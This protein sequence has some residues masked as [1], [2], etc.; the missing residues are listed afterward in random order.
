M[1]EAILL[2][3][4]IVKASRR[5]KLKRLNSEDFSG[6][7][8]ADFSVW[9]KAELKATDAFLMATWGA[10][11]VKIIIMIALSGQRFEMN[12]WLAINGLIILLWLI[13]LGI[14][15]SLGSKAKKLKLAAGIKWPK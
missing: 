9:H 12:S 3:V 6:V 2:I 13:G 10:L 4:G 8:S 5:P 11:I 14:A 1:L 7:E 15:G